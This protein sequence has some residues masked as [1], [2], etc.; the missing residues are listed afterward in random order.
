M[1]KGENVDEKKLEVLANDKP[2]LLLDIDGVLNAYGGHILMLTLRSNN[3]TTNIIKRS[4]RVFVVSPQN[5][6]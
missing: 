3:M 1:S 4:L 5:H 2:L 6:V